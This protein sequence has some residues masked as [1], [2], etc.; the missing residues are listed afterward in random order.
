M[1]KP[2]LKRFADRFL[3]ASES[4]EKR[5]AERFIEDERRLMTRLRRSEE[6]RT[7]EHAEALKQAA[8]KEKKKKRKSWFYRASGVT[9]HDTSVFRPLI[10]IEKQR[11]YELWW[12]SLDKDEQMRLLAASGKSE[13]SFVV[14][15]L[16]QL[17]EADT[18]RGLDRLFK[19]RNYWLLY[20]LF[21]IQV[22]LALINFRWQSIPLT[23]VVCFIAAYLLYV[24]RLIRVRRSIGLRIHC[25]LTLAFLSYLYGTHS[26]TDGKTTTGEM[27][28]GR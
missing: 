2:L 17:S 5:E 24:S 12:F 11:E 8:R 18:P 23:A 1:K 20:A 27:Q 13:T 9:P 3:Q 25:P 7:K 19:V 22:T 16:K 28:N 4:A 10:S 6:E 15:A 14:M 21:V 26:L